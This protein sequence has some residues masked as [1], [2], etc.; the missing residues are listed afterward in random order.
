MCQL[1][2]GQRNIWSDGSHR[3]S[4]CGVWWEV[5]EASP[6]PL[7]P[8]KLRQSIGALSHLAVWL[9]VHVFNSHLRM[10]VQTMVISHS[11]EALPE[12]D[13]FLAWQ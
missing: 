5:G 11:G 9:L 2:G 8:R 4:S 6:S 13:V 10:E 12:W 3:G 7:P 1:A